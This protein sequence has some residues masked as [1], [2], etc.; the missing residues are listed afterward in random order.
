MPCLNVS[1]YV[2]FILKEYDLAGIHLCG[3]CFMFS[4]IKNFKSGIYIYIFGIP[5]NLKVIIQT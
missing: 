1:H 5:L 4:F 3:F 2:S